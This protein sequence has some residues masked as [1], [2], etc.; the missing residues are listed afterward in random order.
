M[1]P[2][3][4]KKTPGQMAA[5]AAYAR[6]L[7]NPRTG[8]SM[9]PV[10]KYSA[11]QAKGKGKYPTKTMTLFQKQKIMSMV[12]QVVE[13]IQLSAIAVPYLSGYKV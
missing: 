1:R 10:K 9:K 13:H 2:T 6:A 11:S 3:Y 5:A 8:K 4:K 7:I 12:K